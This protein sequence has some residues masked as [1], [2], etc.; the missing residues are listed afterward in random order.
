V[1]KNREPQL[2]DLIWADRRSKGLPYHHCG[3]YEGGGQVIHFASPEGCETNPFTAEIH[4]AAYEHFKD[5]CPV[6]I[7]EFENS[8]TAEETLSRAR[9]RIGEHNYDLTTNNCDHFATWCKTGKYR[10]LQVDQVKA[11]LKELDNSVVNIVC[12]I[13]DIAEMIN[14][15]R[16]DTIYPAEVKKQ[17]DN[18]IFGKEKD[19]QSDDEALGALEVKKVFN[20]IKQELKPVIDYIKGALKRLKEEAGLANKIFYEEVMK[21]FIAHKDD[22]PAI[23]KGALLKLPA[24][25]GFLIAQ[26]FLDKNN[27]IVI[28]KLGRPLGYKKITMQLDDELL[29]LFKDEDLIIVE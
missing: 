2:G 29:H 4:R 25:N 17:E 3:I 12:K 19:E 22:S 5:G 14:A 9:S 27:N 7:I 10:S 16:M 21:Y 11:V 26:V 18:M 15:F 20:E 13:H 23:V 28:G 24:E 6:K 1:D 8:L